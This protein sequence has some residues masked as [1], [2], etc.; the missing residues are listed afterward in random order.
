MA[1]SHAL[2]V[3]ALFAALLLALAP[4]FA[5]PALPA[6]Y[7]PPDYQ[8]VLAGRAPLRVLMASH[9][10]MLAWK[11]TQEVRA[12]SVADDAL[13][14]TAPAGE[15][16]GIVHAPAD[17]G[18][19]LR[20]NGQN[21]C[22]LPDAIRLDSAE[23]IQ[24]WSA[25]PEHWTTLSCPL[26]IT[27]LPDGTF[28]VAQEMSLEEYV[29]HVVPAEM[30]SSF[31]PQA[32]RAQAIIARTFALCKLG[33]HADDGAD[34]C[35]DIHCQ[36]YFPT[37]KL[38]KAADAA[39]AATSGIV[40]LYGKTLAEPYYHAC[41]GGAT[42]DAGLVWGPEYAKPYLVGI[43]DAPAGRTAQNLTPQEITAH[44]D[45]YCKRSNSLHWRKTFSSVEVDRLVQRNLP[46]V[47]G[48]PTAKI[49]H[50]TN[51][52]IEER[53]QNGRVATLRIE[54]DGASLLVSGDK[55]RWLFGTGAP[56]AEGLWSTLFDLTLTRDAGGAITGYTV[57]GAGRGHG[58][59][60]CQWG[61]DGRAKAGQSYREILQAYYPGTHLS[62]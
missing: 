9:Q 8:R 41:S 44:E 61:A 46:R 59:G 13:L 31:H 48:D 42:D 39:V 43:L 28:S 7:T 35:D 32:L 6:P 34:L 60:L 33:R 29:R 10:P 19:T 14:Y 47:T 21:F 57:T 15:Q 37:E 53:T 18:N 5:Q 51:M 24:L 40:L 36:A 49:T 4:V 11:G 22:P 62:R 58:I 25:K 50:V 52:T 1:L 17:T 26:V 20:K 27:P 12:R 56:G 2:C 45:L 23:P 3:A 54:G 30:P 55:I 16:V 38:T